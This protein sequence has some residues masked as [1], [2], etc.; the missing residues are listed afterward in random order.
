MAHAFYNFVLH[1]LGWISK[2]K[3]QDSFLFIDTKGGDLIRKYA[4][5]NYF[6]PT[7]NVLLIYD[8]HFGCENRER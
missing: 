2:E 6:P 7:F 1:S 5:W 8:L 3:K 4:N